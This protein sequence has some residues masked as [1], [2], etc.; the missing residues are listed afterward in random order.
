ME[1]IDDKYFNLGINT[2]KKVGIGKEYENKNYLLSSLL[3]LGKYFFE[4]K[5][6]KIL[7][8][9]EHHG[10]FANI[11][12]YPSI[13]MKFNSVQQN[14]IFSFFDIIK[15]DNKFFNDYKSFLLIKFVYY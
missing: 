2:K 7:D 9:S 1:N 8:I 10:F 11:L 3:N 6:K 5:N 15:K 13:L 4:I 12:F 14:F